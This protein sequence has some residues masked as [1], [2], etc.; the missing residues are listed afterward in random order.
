MYYTGRILNGFAGA[1]NTP[2][3]LRGDA[4]LGWR[5]GHDIDISVGVQNAFDPRHL[6]LTSTSLQRPVEV[7]RNVY[8]SITFKF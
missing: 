3:Y 6:E 7:P 2:A 5:P 1:P 8:G 4:R